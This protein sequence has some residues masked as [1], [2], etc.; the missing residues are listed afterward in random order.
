L[1][2]IASDYVNFG[3]QYFFSVPGLRQGDRVLRRSRLVIRGAGNGSTF[4]LGVR[5][6]SGRVF[7]VRGTGRHLV[8]TCAPTGE[9]DC[10]G[11]S[12]SGGTVVSKPKLRALTK[13]E[14]EIV[15]RTLLAATREYANALADGRKALGSQQYANASEGLNAL[16]TDP[17]SEAKRFSTFRQSVINGLNVFSDYAYLKAHDV[18]PTGQVPSALEVWHETMVQA[19]FDLSQWGS[20]AAD[21]LIRTANSNTLEADA[22]AVRRDLARARRAVNEAAR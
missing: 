9:P 8:R 12:W 14:Q 1:K 15:R 18:F 2:D 21:W 3:G 4:S 5:S 10:P 7:R 17:N 22:V 13:A 6:Q 19:Q 16:L 20:D 11:G